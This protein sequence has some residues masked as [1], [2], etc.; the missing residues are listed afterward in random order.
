MDRAECCEILRKIYE[1]GECEKIGLEIRVRSAVLHK[2][3]DGKISV[4]SF[5]KLIGGGYLG[6]STGNSVAYSLLIILGEVDEREREGQRSFPIDRIYTI[7][8]YGT[9]RYWY[10]E[11]EWLLR[12]G[13]ESGSRELVDCFAGSGFIGLLGA[14]IGYEKV[15]LNDLDAGLY[16]YHLVMKDEKEFC[17]FERLITATR[18]PNKKVIEIVDE[19]LEGEEGKRFQRINW[20][21]AVYLFYQKHYKKAG[22]G[23]INVNKKLIGEYR[24]ELEKT[25]KLYKNV[26]VSNYHYKKLLKER[27][28][29]VGKTLF[30]FDPPF[31]GGN[32]RGYNKC[33]TEG[34]HLGM[35]KEIKRISRLGSRIVVVGFDNWM[36]KEWL[37]RRLRFQKIE[38]KRESVNGKRECVWINWK[39]KGE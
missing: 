18:F 29:E 17:K 5:N 20:K 11:W 23:S 37:E 27:E 16:N 25:H 12:E 26:E 10:R 8:W 22:I 15:W 3:L 28:R 34:Q 9:Q 39:V 14:R 4:Q 30:I 21:K 38:S 2:W 7:N 24:E 32:H 33:F 19:Y 6:V 13:L 1:S 31:L 36:Y 35:M